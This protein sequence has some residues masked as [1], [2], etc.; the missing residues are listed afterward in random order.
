MWS[1]ETGETETFVSLQARYTPKAFSGCL[2]LDARLIVVTMKKHVQ[3]SLALALLSLAALAGP[4]RA[5]AAAYKDALV[6]NVPHVKQKPDFCGEACVEMAARQLGRV[7]TQDDV[8]NRSGADPA[9]GRGCV[10]R[11]LLAAM[12]AIGL[13]PGQTYYPIDA[14]K[15]AGEMEAQWKALH[16]DLLKGIP[17]IVCMHYSAKPDAPE[18]FRLIVGYAAKTDEVIYSEP[19]DDKGGGRRMK[20]DLLLQ[21]WPLKYAA[22]KWTVVRLRCAPEAAVKLERPA[23]FT[24]ADFCQ[25]VMELKKKL[26]GKGFTI[27]V[28]PPFV[29]V[30][31]EEPGRVRM[32]AVQ[33]VKWAVERL[34]Q[35][36]FKK[37]PEHILDIWLFRDKDSYEKNT[38][39]VFEEEPDTPYG[40]YS[41]ANRALI[42]N[43][44]TGGGTLIHEIVHPFTR[45]NF[46]RCPAWFFEGLGSLYE[47]SSERDG[48]IVGLTNWRLAGL[49]KALKKGST[50][51][52]EELTGTSDSDFYHL[53]SGTNYAQA[54][55]L[56]YYLQQKG[57]LVRYFREFVANHGKDPSGYDTLK[58]I[59]GEKDMAAFEKTWKDFVLKL[60]FP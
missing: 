45:A 29:V 16:D 31:D 49:Q 14:G 30:G 56:C 42:M 25:H 44:A 48:R 8:F 34:K 4:G 28:Q 11:E 3:R 13:A 54:R 36:Y 9:L 21:L 22:D 24:P 35:D 37:D 40:F 38:L 59:L 19:A 10:T 50:P 26:P 58:E 2:S 32:R 60:T 18:H 23:G 53:D 39:A 12:K 52:F 15:A 20:R 5:Q 43:I 33:T 47:Q 1:T 6:T 41:E 57:L 46:P 27:C 55:Y 51:T 17:S 7:I